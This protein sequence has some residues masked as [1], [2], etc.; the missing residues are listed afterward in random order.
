MTG[1]VD[2]SQRAAPGATSVRWFRRHLDRP[3]PAAFGEPLR[4]GTAPKTRLLVL[5]PTPFCNIDCDYCYLPGRDGKQRMSLDTVRLSAQRL[6]D[7]GLAGESL[8]VV[9]HAGEPLTMPVA[10]YE[11]AFEAVAGVLGATCRVTH[12]VQTNAT[13]IDDAW[14]GLFARHAVRV[15]ISV[16]GP[17]DLHDRH[18]RTRSG[19]GTHA[20]A[21]RGLAQLRA[22][23]IACHAIAVVTRDTLA[24]ADEFFDFFLEQGIHDVGC[25]FDEAEGGH[26]R[27][28]LTG[29]EAAHD[30]FLARLLQRSVDSG[31]QVVVRELA[32]A[33]HRVAQPLPQVAWGGQLWPD[34]AQVMPFALIT[35]AWNGDFGTFSPELL[36]QRSAEFGDFVLGNVARSGFLDRL[37]SVPMQ[38]VWREIARGVEACSRDCAYFG[39][40]GGGAPANK[41]YENGD[42]ASTE[43][44]Y[45]RS[46]V[47]RPLQAVLHR[48]EQERAATATSAGAAA[49]RPLPTG[50]P[51]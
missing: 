5:Q 20:A 17:A 50:E 11:Q 22:H 37:D 49:A 46:M 44:L 33:L 39:L 34:N 48:L 7:D 1:R 2:S 29:H 12:A 36:G 25:N 21:M 26:A 13:L 42:L 45:C 23:G 41:L 27:S 43:T 28:S 24:R 16:D 35:V 10:F 32:A 51:A 47:Q 15:G 6:R 3:Q 40:C 9:W 19:K 38:R 14:C 4:L 31:R 30:A 18:R 8:T